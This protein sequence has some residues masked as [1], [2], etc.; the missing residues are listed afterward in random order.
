MHLCLNLYPLIFSLYLLF[1]PTTAANARREALSAGPDAVALDVESLPLLARTLHEP[2]IK[3]LNY[4]KNVLPVLPL[5]P[6]GVIAVNPYDNTS[7]RI[8]QLRW[9]AEERVRRDGLPKCTC[10]SR[11][12]VSAAAGVTETALEADA[13]GVDAAETQVKET[14]VADGS[15]ALRESGHAANLDADDDALSP[16]VDEGQSAPSD[17]AAATLR[18]PGRGSVVGRAIAR[19]C[20]CGDVPVHR[21]RLFKDIIAADGD[22]PDLFGGTSAEETIEAATAGGVANIPDF[23][24]PQDIG[25]TQSAGHLGSATLFSETTTY[26]ADGRVGAGSR[27]VSVRQD[28]MGLPLLPPGVGRWGRN[29]LGMNTSSGTNIPARATDVTGTDKLGNFVPSEGNATADPAHALSAEAGETL[30]YC[31]EHRTARVTLRPQLSL[32]SPLQS[33]RSLGAVAMGAVVYALFYPMMALWSGTI[34]HNILFGHVLFVT[35]ATA[36]YTAYSYGS[37]TAAALIFALCFHYIRGLRDIEKF[38][39]PLRPSVWRAFQSHWV[40][41]LCHHWGYFQA[42]RLAKLNPAKQYL[43]AFYPHGILIHSKYVAAMLEDIL[44]DRSRHL[45]SI[46]ILLIRN[47]MFLFITP[48]PVSYASLSRTIIPLTQTRPLGWHLP[49]ALPRSAHPTDARR[50]RAVLGARLPR[51][52]RLAGR[53]GRGPQDCRTLH[54]V[55]RQCRCISGRHGGDPDYRCQ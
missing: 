24:G 53:R 40:W 6:P 5:L 31:V 49:L 2:E 43:F 48:F 35:A 50:A 39:D 21:A 45:S 3:V 16:R 8:Q 4:R 42:M 9:E 55:R 37:Y 51:V 17:D 14:P 33:L 12:E 26:Y 23:E 18:A 13:R 34:V 36:L 47:L 22:N 30:P 20:Q 19:L 29:S 15:T 10:G 25:I 44:Y 32:R 1:T 46:I 28:G 54:G 41:R 7:A 38:K 27:P 52:L 11:K